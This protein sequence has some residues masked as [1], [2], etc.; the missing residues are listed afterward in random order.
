MSRVERT[1]ERTVERIEERTEN[2]RR[3][4]APRPDTTPGKAE[5]EV[6][7]VEE[8]LRHQEE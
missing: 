4:T 7:D 1:V 6:D 8:A 2:L 5:G 3:E